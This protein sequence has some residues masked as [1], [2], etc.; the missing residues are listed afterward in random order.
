MTVPSHAHVTVI[1]TG[2]ALAT[3]PTAPAKTGQ[4]M[5]MCTTFA[6]RSPTQIIF[7]AQINALATSTANAISL[8]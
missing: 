4:P 7:I 1:A 5:S 3:I 6:K 8:V 2:A